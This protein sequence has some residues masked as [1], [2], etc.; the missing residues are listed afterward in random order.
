MAPKKTVASTE[1]APAGDDVVGSVIETVKARLEELRPYLEEA[2]RLQAILAASE[3][4]TATKPAE[5]RQRQGS[6]KRTIMAVIAQRPGVTA[7]E[8]ARETGMKRTVVASTVSRLKR[9][10]ELEPEGKGVRL[11]GSGTAA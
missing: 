11:P 6:N 3:G 4:R 2:E 10:G 1:T 7:A 5:P 9:T 8:I